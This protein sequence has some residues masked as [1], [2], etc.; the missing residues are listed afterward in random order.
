MSIVPEQVKVVFKVHAIGR[1][2]YEFSVL[3]WNWY[4]VFW[5]QQWFL[6]CFGRAVL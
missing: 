3:C 5:N 2:W 6:V 4:G 1:N